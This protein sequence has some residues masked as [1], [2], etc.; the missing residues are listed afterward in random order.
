MARHKIDVRTLE[1]QGADG[2][3]RF[4][5]SE[6]W[7]WA[8]W[9]WMGPW[10]HPLPPQACGSAERRFPSGINR[11]DADEEEQQKPDPIHVER[12]RQVDAIYQSLPLE[13]QRVLQMEY[14]RRHE[15]GGMPVR[16]R[17]I[18]AARKIGISVEYYKIALNNIKALVH[19]EFR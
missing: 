1:S 8:R 13:E 14:P 19:K 18:A 11:E 7:N 5:N 3:P 4:I 2:F 16:A 6:L 10:P 15:F 17:Q 12:A 9:C